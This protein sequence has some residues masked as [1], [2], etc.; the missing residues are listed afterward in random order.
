MDVYSPINTHDHHFEPTYFAS[1]GYDSHGDHIECTYN[2][3]T[4]INF[5][6]VEDI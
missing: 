5:D 4:G 6:G 2:V 1:S 3:P